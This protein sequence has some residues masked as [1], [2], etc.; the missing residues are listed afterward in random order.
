MTKQ[1]AIEKVEELAAEYEGSEVI[2]F[3]QDGFEVSARVF[4]THTIV[5]GD[6]V[7]P[8][9]HSVDVEVLDF[10]MKEITE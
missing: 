8:D 7:T 2:E 10:E 5:K 1:E 6:N 4:V 9:N 3:E